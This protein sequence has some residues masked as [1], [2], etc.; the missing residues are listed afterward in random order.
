MRKK[1][2]VSAFVTVLC[3]LAGC[4]V[5]QKKGSPCEGDESLCPTSLRE[6]TDVACDCHCV[7]GYSGIT[8]TREFD[9]EISTCLPPALNPAIGS[10]EQREA[11]AA[12]TDVQF[13]Q[14][15]FKFCSDTVA[16]YLG[17][18]IEQQQRPKDMSAACVGPRIRCSCG[19][20]GATEVTPVCSSPCADTECDRTNCQP[21][22]KVGNVIDAVGCGCSRVSACG[23]VTPAPSEPPLC[24]NRVNAAIR[25]KARKAAEAEAA[26]QAEAETPN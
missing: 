3:V 10:D 18:L 20:K 21:M 1:L 23:D 8:P 6:A 13:N 11:A 4:A 22:L 24:M 5:E 14:R 17:D 9:G 19:T 16:S 25:R 15:V 2:V 7:A 26:A 12:M